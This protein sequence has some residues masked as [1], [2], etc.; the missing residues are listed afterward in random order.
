[1]DIKLLFAVAA[2][3]IGLYSFI[4]YIRDMLA[5]TTKPHAYTWLIWTI[6]QAVATVGIWTGGGG[7]SA[8]GLTIGTCLVGVIF[9]LSLLYGT[10]DITRFD[11]LLLLG[12]LSGIVVWYITDSILYAVILATLVDL[13]GY[14][15]SFRKTWADPTSETRSMWV[16]WVISGACSLLGLENYNALTT[17]YI[18]MCLCMNIIMT[19][20]VF[21]KVGAQR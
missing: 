21:R 12:A 14:F 5:G 11:T 6:T 1:M 8:Y 9:I 7:W 18:G 17:L 3:C 19:T 13:V 10:K 2:T 4:P 16:L 20:L 15:P